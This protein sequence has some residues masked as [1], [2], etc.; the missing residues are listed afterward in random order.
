MIRILSAAFFLA[1]V[2]PLHAPAATCSGTNPAITAAAV[3][4]VSSA[5]RLN[6]YHLAG[7]VTNRGTMSEPSNTLQF[8]DVFVDGQ[9]RDDR[10][11]PPLAVGQSYSFGF[12]WLRSIDA[13]PGSTTVL[14]RLR[15][16]D[17][18]NCNPA[19]GSRSVTF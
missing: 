5:D 8:V 13:G 18:V 10:G 4:N 6:T 16:V 15:M 3:K 12:D 9:R 11:I 14:F 17:G 1:L 2:V 19:N 7:T